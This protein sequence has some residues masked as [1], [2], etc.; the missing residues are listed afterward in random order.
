MERI[1]QPIREA[2]EVQL[3]GLGDRAVIDL[4]GALIDQSE[5]DQL[6]IDAVEA[7]VIAVGHDR[8][9]GGGG[10]GRAVQDR[11]VRGRGAL[12]HLEPRAEDGQ[13]GRL[14]PVDVEVRFLVE[15]VL[16]D[17]RQEVSQPADANRTHGIG[18]DVAWE[19]LI[20]IVVVVEC[21][22]ELV[23]V[24]AARHSGRGLTDFLHGRQEQAD[25]DGDDG[26]HDQ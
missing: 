3:G 4:A 7:R 21:E 13:I 11:A 14:V 17:K 19:S 6:R 24:V 12:E 20:G 25:Q 26:D 8:S 5:C 18:P 1:R 10:I 15:A 22:P 2:R 16:L 9:P 23:Q